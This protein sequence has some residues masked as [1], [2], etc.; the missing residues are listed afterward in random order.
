LK[1]DSKN[2]NSDQEPVPPVKQ[3]FH[4]KQLS[5]FQ[6]FLC[7]SPDERSSLSNTI[8]LWDAVPKY[9][10]SKRAQEDL[11]E[12]GFL[13]TIEKKFVFKK[14]EMTVTLLPARL[15]VDGKA[16]EFFPSAREELVEDVLR[17]IACNAGSGYLDGDRSGV[18]FTLHQLRKE[19]SEQGHTFSY[20]QV[21]ESLKI[22][23]RSSLSISSADGKSFYETSP[24]TTLAAVSREDLNANPE[25][26]WY[27]D[28]SAL[29]TEGI[30]QIKYRQYN[31]GLMMSLKGQLTRYLHKRLSHNFT[32]ASLLYSYTVTLSSVARDSGLLDRKK[33]S[34]N[35]RKFEESLD[36][37]I[38]EKVLMRY[39]T[40]ETRGP[41]NSIVDIKYDLFPDHDFISEAKRSNKRLSIVAGG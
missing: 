28:F 27:A 26:R 33:I 11:R 23:R 12:G 3:A 6:D 19:L 16:K 31:Y 13:P 10:I 39:E 37:L 4:A 24:L 9:Y 1:A 29:V 30:K 36:E 5:L 7:N 32:Q 15:M 25:S 14:T 41:R 18:S 35:K 17:K 21:V 2:A 22:L 38:K 34:D 40:E 20:Y 8:E